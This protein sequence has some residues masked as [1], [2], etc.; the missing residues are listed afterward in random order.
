MD[1]IPL[2]GDEIPDGYDGWL[3]LF[4]E[5]TSAL[6]P[7]QAAAYKPLCEKEVG[8]AKVHPNVAMVAA[9]NL[10]TDNA[11]VEPMSTALQSRLIH[12][13]MVADHEKWIE[14]AAKK[15]L[16][17]R[18]TSYIKFKPDMLYTFKPD[19]TDKTYAS[20]RTWE[21]ASRLTKKHD[22]LTMDHLSLLS[23]AVSEGVAREFI[24]FCKVYT[25]LPTIDQILVNPEGITIPEEPSILFALTGSVA[26]NAKPS[27]LETLMRFITRLHMEWQVVCLR[28]LIR[29]DETA[30]TSEPIKEWISKN[31]AELFE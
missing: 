7:V 30:L 20:P 15:G 31:S 27:N 19:H 22:K 24:Q 16:D 26:A 25:E 2:E 28:D 5:L 6:S 18:I 14:W 3:V 9:G 23:G 21:Y 17:H 10:E 11:V 4:D 12:F 1:T 29:R 8:N 13:E